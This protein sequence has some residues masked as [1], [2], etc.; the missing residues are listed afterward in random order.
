M[1]PTGKRS[2]TPFLSVASMLSSSRDERFFA[3]D[4]L[5]PKERLSIDEFA[6]SRIIN[7]HPEWMQDELAK[8][9]LRPMSLKIR[10]KGGRVPLEG[11]SNPQTLADLLNAGDLSS[12]SEDGKHYYRIVN[13]EKPSDEEARDFG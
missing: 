5:D 8:A 12:Y 13:K 2:K 6:R 3:L 11:I 9:E 1:K 7:D 4:Q 10:L